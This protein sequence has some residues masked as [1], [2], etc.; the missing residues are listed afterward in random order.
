MHVKLTCAWSLIDTKN[1]AISKL[2]S[3]ITQLLYT[4]RLEQERYISIYGPGT[5]S[6]GL[7]LFL[8][9]PC[10]IR[11]FTWKRN[12]RDTSYHGT[13]YIHFRVHVT[14]CQIK[15]NDTN[16]HTT[17]SPSHPYCLPSTRFFFVQQQEH[18]LWPNSQTSGQFFLNLIGWQS[19]TS[20][21]RMLTKPDID[22]VHVCAADQKNSGLCGLDWPNFITNK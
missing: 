8:H 14:R 9:S 22:R 19:K 3:I 12:L 21:L 5:Q 6:C 7:I 17:K 15:Q 13:H 20:S 1:Y 18:G 10:L 2:L 11:C 4:L 16:K